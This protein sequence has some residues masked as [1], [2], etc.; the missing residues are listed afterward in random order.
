[1]LRVR[2][3]CHY[4]DSRRTLWLIK[5]VKIGLSKLRPS[6]PV[7]PVLQKYHLKHDYRIALEPE[8]GV[9]PEAKP[10]IL[11]YV[12]VTYV[13]ASKVSYLA[14]YYSN[15]PVIPV[16]YVPVIEPLVLH[17][18]K[19]LDALRSHAPKEMSPR[20][21][22]R[23]APYRIVH[24]LYLHTCPRPLYESLPEAIA[25]V[26]ILYYIIFHMDML[27]SLRYVLEQLFKLGYPLLE[28]LKVIAHS[29]RSIS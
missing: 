3:R 4:L 21:Q 16:V 12:F 24:Y 18:S 28:Y 10:R 7:I 17:E 13:Y 14:V 20:Y 19:Y 6:R 25:H 8:M 1:M 15:L 27:L 22:E 23:I 29:Y 5:Y 9:S 2:A 11:M 26:V